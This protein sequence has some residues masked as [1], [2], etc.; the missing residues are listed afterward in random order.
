MSKGEICYV[1]L[2]NIHIQVLH[3]EQFFR[4]WPSSELQ[5]HLKIMMKISGP[6]KLTT[7]SQTRLEFELSQVHTSEKR[8][9]IGAI[10]GGIL[11]GFVIAVLLIYCAFFIRRRRRRRDEHPGIFTPFKSPNPQSTLKPGIEESTVPAIT[12]YFVDSHRIFQK[13]TE[14]NQDIRAEV[15]VLRQ[16]LETLREG[17]QGGGSFER[18]DNEAPPSYYHQ[19]SLVSAAAQV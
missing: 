12:E 19:E 1:T 2:N 11:S 9:N 3:R 18:S 6:S 7:C 4:S 8:Y 10:V 17:R 16:E 5:T 15:N 13:Q 14:A